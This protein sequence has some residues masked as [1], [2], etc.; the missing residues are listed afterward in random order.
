MQKPIHGS[1]AK[2]YPQRFQDFRI[3]TCRKAEMFTIG[4]KFQLSNFDM[5]F[6]RMFRRFC[7]ISNLISFKNVS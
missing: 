1:R 7:S 3:S 5:K 2:K 6:R 4:P